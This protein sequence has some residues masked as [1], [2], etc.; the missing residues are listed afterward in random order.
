[1][2]I[3]ISRR[4]IK[5][6]AH[7]ALKDAARAAKA[8]RRCIVDGCGRLTM[9]SVPIYSHDID[10]PVCTLHRDYLRELDM[11][12]IH[13]RVAG[14]RE[15][16]FPAASAYASVFPE[17]RFDEDGVPNSDIPPEQAAMAVYS[18][19]YLITAELREA[20]VVAVIE[21]I[22]GVPHLVWV[23]PWF[24]IPYD[25]HLE[26]VITGVRVTAAEGDPPLSYAEWVQILGDP[27]EVIELANFSGFPEA[28]AEEEDNNEE[29]EEDL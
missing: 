26:E 9:A 12:V 10:V 4:L 18:A 27:S 20:G 19:G 1:M 17:T 28:E 6:S 15:D 14:S 16:A 25:P 24:I 29:E 11:L 2:N 22:K 23:D 8:E 5:G 21:R 13:E 7:K 3:V